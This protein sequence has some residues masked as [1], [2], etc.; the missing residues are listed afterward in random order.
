MKVDH[1]SLAD[2][3]TYHIKEMI[4]S[5]EIKSDEYLPPQPELACSFGV[6]LSTI[7][8]AIKGLS[9]VG[10]VDPQPG[11]GTY[12]HPD[13][14]SLIRMLNFQQTR[15]EGLDIS[16]LYEVRKLIETEIVALA[17]ERATEQEIAEIRGSL[18]QMQNMVNDSD[19]YMEA[20]TKF[21][22]SVARACHNSLLEQLYF[23]VSEAM[24]DINLNIADVPG[25]KDYG[26]QLQ[27]EIY[28]AIEQRQPA[29]ARQR[30][31]TLI[32]RW[33]GVLRAFKSENPKQEKTAI[34][35]LLASK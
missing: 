2:Q 12:V 25:I 3:V 30:A 34:R 27:E 9:L 22:T 17:A 23:I 19:A 1:S 20:D 10:I 6:G 14:A 28:E 15:L 5:G 13:A 16:M 8:E 35:E 31:T 33:Y 26:L 21:H 7:R 32:N 24:H 29:I 11:R 18:A 4:L